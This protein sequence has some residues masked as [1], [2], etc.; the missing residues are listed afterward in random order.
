MENRETL[1]LKTLRL[2]VILSCPKFFQSLDLVHLHSHSHTLG[3][4]AAGTDR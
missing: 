4:D 1:T 2:R 3:I